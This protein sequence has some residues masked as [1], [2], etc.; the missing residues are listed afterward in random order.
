MNPDSLS[1]KTIE[2]KLKSRKI[3]LMIQA[4]GIPREKITIKR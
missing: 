3:S 1:Y 4:I 2:I